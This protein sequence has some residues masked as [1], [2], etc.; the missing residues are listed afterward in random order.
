MLMSKQ[1]GIR[2]QLRR[3]NGLSHQERGRREGTEDELAWIV[4]LQWALPLR[5]GL[6]VWE[7]EHSYLSIPDDSSFLSWSPGNNL[8]TGHVHILGPD[9]VKSA[10]WPCR[11]RLHPCLSNSELEGA[12]LQSVFLQP[13]SGVGLCLLSVFYEL[14]IDHFF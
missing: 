1:A 3:L 12:I 5:T 10:A 2:H 4:T 11:S 7:R 13:V 8:F 9:Y 6:C 14:I